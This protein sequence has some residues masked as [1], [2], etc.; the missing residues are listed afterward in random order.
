MKID[1]DGSV[2]ADIM[3]NLRKSIAQNS[4]ENK[5][6][7]LRA[8]KTIFICNNCK[9]LWEYQISGASFQKNKII[10]YTEIPSYGKKYKICINCKN[11]KKGK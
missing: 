7:D 8:D 11:K 6:K 2:I 10:Y 5:S 4:R 1:D 3:L 9:R